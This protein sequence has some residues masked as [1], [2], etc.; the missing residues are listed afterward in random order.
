VSFFYSLLYLSPVLPED[1]LP[2]PYQIFLQIKYSL[3]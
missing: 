3:W 2:V 1:L